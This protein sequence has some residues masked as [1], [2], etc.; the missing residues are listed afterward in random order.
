MILKEYR[1]A[2]GILRR[3]Y[4]PHEG[5][6]P[7]QGIPLSVD[8]DAYLDQIKNDLKVNVYA[9]LRERGLIEPIDFLQPNAPKL[10]RA[11]LLTALPDVFAIQAIAK[12]Q[13]N[14]G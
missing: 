12:E 5:V 13:A 11:A 10:I 7:K 1:D 3:V 9:A 8:I 4:V 6:D 14:D 2:E